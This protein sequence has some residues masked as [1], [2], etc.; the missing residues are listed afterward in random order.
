MSNQEKKTIIETLDK[1]GL[2][3]VEHEHKWTIEERE[4]YDKSILLLLPVIR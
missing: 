1:L 3:L 4:L 2:A